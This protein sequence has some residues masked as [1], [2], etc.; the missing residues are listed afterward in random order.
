[1]TLRQLAKMA[2]LQAEVAHMGDEKR[3]PRRAIITIE[4]RGPQTTGR[5]QY[6]MRCMLDIEG[7]AEKIPALEIAKV[8]LS[9]Y[10]AAGALCSFDE[11]AATKKATAI[12][13]IAIVEQAPDEPS[14]QRL[15]S[16]L[17]SAGFTVIIKELRECSQCLSSVMVPWN[18]P[19]TPPPGWH[20]GTICGKHQYKSCPSCNSVYIM[21]STNSS[22]PAPSLHCTV[23]NEILVEWGGTKLWDAELVSS[24][25]AASN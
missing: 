8:A 19:E 22:G 18:Q 23:C 10:A 9:P 24:S 4:P 20:L 14:V 12:E 13:A 25:A 2:I 1:M 6:L 3:S 17:S 21:R 11:V 5:R 15:R 7:A 16:S